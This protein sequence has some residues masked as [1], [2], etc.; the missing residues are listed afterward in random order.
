MALLGVGYIGGS[1]ALAA[2]RAGIALRIVGY[3]P[4]PKALEVALMR[5]VLDVAVATAAEAA[6]EADLVLLAGPVGSLDALVLAI[7][8]V[9]QASTLIIDVGSVKRLLVEHTGARLLKGQLV[10]CHP[11]AGAEFVGVAAADGTI[12]NGRLCYLCPSA[13]ASSA[14]ILAVEDFWKGLGSST[15]V[16]DPGLH[17]RLMAAQSHLPH[18]AAFALAAALADE[19]PFLEAQGSTPTTSLRDTTRIA[20]SSPTVWRDIFLANATELLPLI[21]R[22]VSIVEALESAIVARDPMALQAILAQAQASRRR[23]VKE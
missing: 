4:D 1:V 3:D 21:Q 17:D 19:I 9:L 18:M 15:L 10:G 23:L 11:M 7:A 2:R 13:G 16:I 6:T 8:P 14:A 22:F 5:G 20:A 12:F